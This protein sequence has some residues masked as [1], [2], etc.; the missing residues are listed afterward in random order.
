MGACRGI[1]KQHLYVTGAHIFSRHFIGAARIAGDAAHDIQHIHL[2]ERSG[3]Q[4]FG[5]VQLQCNFGKIAR[6]TRGSPRE[7]HIIHTAAA[8]RR[9]AVFTHHP[10][11]RFKQI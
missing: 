6:R 4:A 8:H 7:N 11:Q 5:I 2:V 10:T 3:C 1:G 9:G